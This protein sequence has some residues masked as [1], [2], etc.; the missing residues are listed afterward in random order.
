MPRR[1]FLDRVVGA[2]GK[3]EI[4][5]RSFFI[6]RHRGLSG[7]NRNPQSM[8]YRIGT[9][10]T[11]SPIIWSEAIAAKPLC[12]WAHDELR[13]CIMC[14]GPEEAPYLQNG[15]GGRP[16]LMLASALVASN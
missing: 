6:S 12:A 9:L 13:Q 14:F 8:Y 1:D 16:R 15:T 3:G 4:P 11:D 5:R 10:E 7:L 2:T